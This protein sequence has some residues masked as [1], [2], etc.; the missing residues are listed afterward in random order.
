MKDTIKIKVE[1]RSLEQPEEVYNEDVDNYEETG[2]NVT[3]YDIECKVEI[4]GKEIKHYTD[5]F[6]FLREFVN[7]SV[8]SNSANWSGESYKDT[9]TDYIPITKSWHYGQSNFYPFTCSCGVAGCSSIWDGIHVKWRK[10][11]VEWRIKDKRDGYEDLLDKMFYSFDR[12]QYEKEVLTAYKT[13]CKLVE[14]SP[15]NESAWMVEEF[16]DKIKDK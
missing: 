2:N 13:L 12:K 3:K 7:K 10:N 1:E 11:S 16:K 15:E 4:N 8:V 14:K 9:G 5:L 6:A